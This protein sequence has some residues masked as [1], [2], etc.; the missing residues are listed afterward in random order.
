MKV[1]GLLYLHSIGQNRMT[2]SSL[3]TYELFRSICGP[4]ALGRVVMASTQWDTVLYDP[5]AGPVREGDLKDFWSTTLAQGAVYRRVNAK[6]PK[7]DTGAIVDYIL[8]KYALATQKLF[9]KY[10]ACVKFLN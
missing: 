9:S 2:G 4:L 10:A 7:R 5:S 8:Q 1:A 6:D 3:L